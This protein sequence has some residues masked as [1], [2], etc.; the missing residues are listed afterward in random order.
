MDKN[1]ITAIVLA[2]GRG[3]RM[4]GVDKGLQLFNG[5][6]LTLQAKQRLASQV[7][8]VIIN[9]NRNLDTYRTLGSDVYPDDDA[10]FAGPLS[11][12]AVGLAHCETPY[13]LTVPCDSPRFP[14]DLAHRLAINMQ[15]DLEQD[16]YDIAMAAQGGWTQPV[17]C[18]IKRTLLPDLLEFMASG[19]RKIDAWTAQHK[20]VIVN[21][22]EP[23][24]DPL[25]F[26]NVNTLSE[27]SAL[28]QQT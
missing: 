13:L 26:A 25:A 12:F 28:Q 22:D 15:K 8:R 18:L 6:P 19:K 9:A 7:G 14:I 24:D 4:G 17:F 20:T 16:D 27:L 23:H 11:G 21:F 3:T 10:E 5:R 1:D 2:G